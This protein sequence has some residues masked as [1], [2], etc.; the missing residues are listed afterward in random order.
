M[1]EKDDI[2]L[3]ALL[4]F[5]PGALGATALHWNIEQRLADELDYPERTNDGFSL[6][7]LRNRI[8]RLVDVGLIEV[9]RE[10]GNYVAISKD[11]RLYLN[12]D[13]DVSERH[14]SELA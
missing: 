4:H 8:T 9:V 14:H 2:I 7:T 6:E 12:G 1:N 10:K 5:S 13:L 3:E 11:G